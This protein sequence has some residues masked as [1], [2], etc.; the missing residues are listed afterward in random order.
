MFKNANV[1]NTNGSAKINAK[2]GKIWIKNIKMQMC[3]W[4]SVDTVSIL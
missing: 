1:C 3:V 4:S 2:Y